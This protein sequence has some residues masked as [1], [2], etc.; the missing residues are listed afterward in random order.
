VIGTPAVSDFDSDGRLD[1][2]YSAVWSSITPNDEDTIPELKVFAFTLEERYKMIA[3]PEVKGE[4]VVD[5]ELFLP[6]DQQP[7]N[8]YMGCHGNN[9]YH[10]G[11]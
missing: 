9:V 6:A 4:V 1:V 11:G 2:A 3:G 7:W 10:R 8:R 5:F